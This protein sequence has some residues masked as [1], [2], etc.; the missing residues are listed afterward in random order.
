MSTKSGENLLLKKESYANKGESL[1]EILAAVTVFAITIGA[2]SGIFISAVRSQRRVLATQELLDQTSYVL[3]YTGRAL[4]MAKKELNAPTCLSSNGLNYEIPLAYQIGG[5]ENLG[6]GIRFINHLQND[7]CQ[8]FFLDGNQ[9]KYK[10]KIGTVDETTLD[11]TSTKLQVNS[12]K[13]NLSGKTQPL[14]DYLQPRV[15]IFLEIF[16][17]GPVGEKP[18]IQIQTSVSQR[19]LDVQYY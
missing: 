16:G 3:E 15:T 7:D 2:I 13:I 17:R 14:T 12:L 6:R 4:R 1:I 9:L 10:I 19:E 5:D 18:K 8:E 11:F